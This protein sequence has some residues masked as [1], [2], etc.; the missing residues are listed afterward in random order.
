[1]KWF[2]SSEK[3]E[4][5]TTRMNFLHAIRSNKRQSQR[6]MYQSC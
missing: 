1:M 2:G 4:S 5:E 3:N 6:K